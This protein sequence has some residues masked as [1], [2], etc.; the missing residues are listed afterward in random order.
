MAEQSRKARKGVSKRRKGKEPRLN[1][2][3][4]DPTTYS[5]IRHRDLFAEN[6]RDTEMGDNRFWCADQ[7]WIY[8]DVYAK[9]KI[10]PMRPLIIVVA[11]EKQQLAEAMH[12]TERMGLHHLMSL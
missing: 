10:R 1:Y 11:Q 5:S 4:M 2:K 6:E 9:H 12:V 3:A 7:R 8:E